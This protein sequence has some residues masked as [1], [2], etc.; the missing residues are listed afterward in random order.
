MFPAVSVRTEW[1]LMQ[2]M[3]ISSVGKTNGAL[4]FE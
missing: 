2:C 3:D 1:V 4:V